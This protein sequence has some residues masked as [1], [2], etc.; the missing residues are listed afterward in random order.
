MADAK[1][2]I[3]DIQGFSVHDGPGSRTT[4]FLSGCPLKCRWC[5]NPEGWKV[6]QRVMYSRQKCRTVQ[7]GCRRCI[8]ACSKR[9]ISKSDEG[10]AIDRAL[11]ENCED[12]S[13]T[14]SCFK[15]ALRL[16]GKWYLPQELME[17]LER[18]RNYWTCGGVTFSGGE[19]LMQ[20]DFILDVLKRCKAAGIHTAVE[21]TAFVEPAFFLKA[22]SYVD[23][24]FIDIK[25]M[26]DVMHRAQTGVSNRLIL[27]NIKA[28]AESAWPGRFILRIP[29]IKGYNDSED[30]ILRAIDFMTETKLREINLLPFHRMGDSKWSQLGERYDYREAETPRDDELKGL[31][32]LFSQRGLSCYIAEDVNY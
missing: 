30:N 18:D 13:C 1:G 28:L 12:F 11:C 25:H 6:K 4:V 9:A 3:F 14:E 29:V 19:P 32:K 10:I 21:T 24:A 7:E 27:S 31:Q 23:F 22:M 17:I 15:E 8:E 26:D 2:L 20:K 16:S 5:A